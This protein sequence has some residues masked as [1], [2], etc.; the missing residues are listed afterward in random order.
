MIEFAHQNRI[1]PAELAVLRE[2]TGEVPVRVGQLAKA[3]GLEVVLATLPMNI[4][5]MI[6]PKGTGYVIKVNRF[7]PKE[8]QRFTIAHEIAHFLLHKQRILQGVTDSV[9]YRSRLSSSLE[10]EANRLAAD[11]IM[12]RE[13]IDRALAHHERVNEQVVADLAEQFRV[14]SAAMQIRVS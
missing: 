6:H 14:S 1:A 10:A 12:P 4:S 5:G 7:E 8:R 11:I 9:L 13:A 3:L 2:Y